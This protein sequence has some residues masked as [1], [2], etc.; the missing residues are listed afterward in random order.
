MIPKPLHQR[1]ANP[2][3]ANIVIGLVAWITATLWYLILTDPPA[4]YRF[5][6]LLWPFG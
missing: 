6:R 4:A 1:P 3:P 2:W 5:A